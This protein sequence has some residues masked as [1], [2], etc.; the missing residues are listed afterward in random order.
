MVKIRGTH[1]P[2]NITYSTI[3]ILVFLDPDAVS[4]SVIQTR[5]GCFSEDGFRLVQKSYEG[6]RIQLLDASLIISD[7]DH[8]QLNM[9]R[10]VQDGTSKDKWLERLKLLFSFVVAI[11]L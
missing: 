4:Q 2:A 11:L 7:K 1:Q 10:I 8:A 6:A 9:N 5:V 3:D